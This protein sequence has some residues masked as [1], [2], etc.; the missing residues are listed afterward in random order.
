MI[1]L[2]G[3]LLAYHGVT[4]LLNDWRGMIFFA[5]TLIQRLLDTYLSNWQPKGKNLDGGTL[6]AAVFVDLLWPL[7]PVAVGIHKGNPLLWTVGFLLMALGT[8]VRAAAMFTLGRHFTPEVRIQDAH[9]LITNGVYRYVRHPFYLGQLAIWFGN[10]LVYPAW[11]SLGLLFISAI[12]MLVWR[13]TVEERALRRY[14]GNR[15]ALYA[16]GTSHLIPGL[17]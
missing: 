10:L 14:F 11:L 13:I 12:P 7:V 17:W 1:P 6:Y 4:P 8:A 16:Q 9:E 3:I 2:V 5:L 15:Y